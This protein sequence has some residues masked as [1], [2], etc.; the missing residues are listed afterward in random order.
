MAT[1]HSEQSREAAPGPL[2]HPDGPRRP[3][4]APRTGAAV[5]LTAVVVAV[6]L[7]AACSSSKSSSSS[8]TSAVAA[9]SSAAATGSASP[10]GS[11]AAS[12]TGTAP[13]DPAAATAEITATWEKFFSPQ[14][15]LA[16]K[17]ALLQNGDQLAPVL[18]GF[19][20]DPRVGQ[21]QAKVTSVQFTSATEATVTYSLSIQGNV[22]QPDATGTAV[23]EN[24]TWK[25]SRS[26]LCGLVQ[27]SGNT[28]VPGCS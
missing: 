14:T 12:P 24:G 6:L 25:V 18:Q 23:L 9:T 15:T 17:G 10:S 22:V 4:R 28:A 3:V 16:D 8:T 20:S 5:R 26:T 1:T 19:A 13:A 21:V 7:A 2:P 27:Q 11:A